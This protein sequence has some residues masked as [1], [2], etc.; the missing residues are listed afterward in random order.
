MEFELKKLSKAAIPAALER[1][2]RYRLLNEPALAE[3]ICQDVLAIDPDNREAIVLLILALSDQFTQNIVDNLDHAWSLLPR[4]G[5]NI[6]TPTIKESSSN[7]RR[8]FMCGGRL[9][10]RTF[11]LTTF[12]VKPCVCTKGLKISGRRVM[13]KPCCDGTPVPARSWEAGLRNALSR[14]SAQCWSSS[15]PP[16][17]PCVRPRQIPRSFFCSIVI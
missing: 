1:A 14:I 9:P 10:D 3:S 5:T 7:A 17:G 2:E 8:A 12:S 4:L 13:M 11:R 15:R 16:G 6:C